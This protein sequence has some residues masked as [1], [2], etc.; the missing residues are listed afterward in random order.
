MQDYTETSE[1][2]HAIEAATDIVIIQADNPDGD[3][4]ASALAL[5]NILGDMGKHVA[6]FCA[7]DMPTYLRYIPGWSRVENE[8]PHSFDLSIIVDTSAVSLL[9]QL[10]S[11]GQIDRLKAKPCIVIDHHDVEA[12]I[13]FATLTINYPAV[14]TGEIVYE[15]ARQC[16]WSINQEAKNAV[17]VSILSDSLGLMTA[18][19]TARSIHIIGELVEQGVN[20]ASLETLRRDMMRKTPQ[21]VHYKGILLQRIEY[22]AA[23]RIATLTIPW[24]EIET[25]SPLYNPSVLALDDM[26][27][28][29]NTAIAIAFKVYKDGKVTG[30]IRCNYGITIANTLAEHF[31]GGGHIYASGFKVSD[32]RPFNELKAECIRYATEL[33]DTLPAK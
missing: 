3:S 12:T 33:L 17:A 1:F 21:L 28:T 32:G 8:L 9:E 29:E 16:N 25:Y 30:K 2:V 14:A 19:T 15:L 22:H 11:H 24:E 5:E 23:D 20:L 7:I 26:R 10:S 13:T 6:L 4:L 27:L 18:A 31:G